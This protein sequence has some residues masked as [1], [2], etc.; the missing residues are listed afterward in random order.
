M[1]LL[2][3]LSASR[4]ILDLTRTGLVTVGQENIPTDGVAIVISNHRSFLDAPILIQALRRTVHIACHHYMGK[5]PL[6][7][8]VVNE[9]GCF[10]FDAP[11]KRHATFFDRAT[12]YLK[13]G[14]WIGLFPEG[15]SPMVHLTGPREIGTFHKGFAHLALR[16]PIENLS[17]IPIAVVSESESVF[18][19]FPVRFLRL[20]DRSEPLFDRDD[21]HPVVMYHSVK[22]CIGRPYRIGDIDRSQYQGKQGKKAV[23]RLMAHC[24]DEISDL[25]AKG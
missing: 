16:C 1:T 17:V 18:A 20:F 8:D 10:P 4:S 5:T 3:P 22:A 13:A 19:P 9:L 21:W 2:T 6:L 25:L 24:R 23:D 7:R 14:H 11:E 15:G 12:T